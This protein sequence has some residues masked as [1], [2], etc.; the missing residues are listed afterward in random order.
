MKCHKAY[1]GPWRLSIRCPS[2]LARRSLALA[3]S[4]AVQRLFHG[5]PGL[6]IQQV[7]VVGERSHVDGPG[8]AGDRRFGGNDEQVIA[9][10]ETQAAYRSRPAFPTQSLQQGAPR[11]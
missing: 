10:P 1:P 8:T 2:N 9:A 3:P 4:G 11:P 5:L 6:R 7:A